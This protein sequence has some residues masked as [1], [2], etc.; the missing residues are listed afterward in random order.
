MMK[1]VKGVKGVKKGEGVKEG[2]KKPR[3]VLMMD[4]MQLRK[5]LELKLRQILTHLSQ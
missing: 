5:K 1:G 4:M 2:E 3:M